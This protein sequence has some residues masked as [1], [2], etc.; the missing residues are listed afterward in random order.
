VAAVKITQVRAFLHLGH[1]SV[2]FVFL[3]GQSSQAVV[4]AGHGCE[5]L[6]FASQQ[7]QQQQQQATAVPCCWSY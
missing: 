3:E 4:A 5:G 6:L 1:S 2:A 7:Q